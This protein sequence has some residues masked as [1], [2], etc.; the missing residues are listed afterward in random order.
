MKKWTL[1]EVACEYE[2]GK[3]KEPFYHLVAMRLQIGGGDAAQACWNEG[4]DPLTGEKRD[5]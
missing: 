3:H 4:F 1:A 5:A 2:N